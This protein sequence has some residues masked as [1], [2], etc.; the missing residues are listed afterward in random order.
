MEPILNKFGEIAS[1]ITYNQPENCRFVSNV[2]GQL[3]TNDFV[4]DSNYWSKHVRESVKFMDGIT[5]LTKNGCNIFIE[6]SPHPVLTT[7]DLSVCHP[8]QKILKIYYGYL[9]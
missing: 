4:I 8:H 9:P 1:T 6:I 7:M 5:T 3:V 2:I